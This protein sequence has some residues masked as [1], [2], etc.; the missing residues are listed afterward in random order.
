MKNVFCLGV[1]AFGLLSGCSGDEEP[2]EN[3][4]YFVR[5]INCSESDIE[6]LVN[7]EPT[8]ALCEDGRA[9]V[10]VTMNLS[11]GTFTQEGQNVEISLTTGTDPSPIGLVIEDDNQS[12]ED[13][14]FGETWELTDTPKFFLCATPDTSE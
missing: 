7:C 5:P 13:D 11:S 12:A 1:L 10:F 2:N 9:F 14:T 4:R 6:A 3:D 8:L